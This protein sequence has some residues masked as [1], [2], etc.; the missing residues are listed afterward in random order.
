[1]DTLQLARAFAQALDAEDYQRAESLL[2]EGCVYDSPDGQLRGAQAIVESYRVH[3]DRARKEFDE[4]RYDSQV[5]PVGPLEFQILYR[6]HLR[7]GN[8]DHT[9]QCAQRIRIGEAGKIVSISHEEIPGE[10]ARLNEFRARVER[11]VRTNND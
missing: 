11:D 8:H 6:D 3:S 7:T 5:G 1:M 4:V 10:R 9:F 2:A